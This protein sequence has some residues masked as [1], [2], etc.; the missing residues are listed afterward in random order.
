MGGGHLLH[1]YNSS[2]ASMIKRLTAHFPVSQRYAVA[3]DRGNHGGVEERA[4]STED[5]FRRAA[6]EKKR[7]GFASQTLE[8]AE[9]GAGEAA[10]K[11]SDF[12][13]VKESYK[14]AP[15]RGKFHKTG[16]AI[17]PENVP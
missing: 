14:D 5:E 6:E 13:S 8:K 10:E 12:E 9:D 7:Q 4:P 16:D 3:S 15:P 11:E 2:R 17:P 1:L